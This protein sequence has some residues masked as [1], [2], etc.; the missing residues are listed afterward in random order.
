MICPYL[1]HGVA[2]TAF[3]RTFRHDGK[4]SA[5]WCGG[6]CTPIPFHS[7]YHHIQSCSV[8]SSWVGRYTH[9]ISSLPIYVLCGPYLISRLF[10]HFY[11]FS[12]AEF[13]GMVVL[14]H[15]LWY[16]LFLT[17]IHTV[18]SYIH[19]WFAI[20]QGLP[21]CI[22]PH[23]VLRCFLFRGMARNG[24]PIPW[25]RYTSSFHGT[26]FQVVF[27]NGSGVPKVSFYFCYTDRN[28]EFFLSRRMV[29]NGIPRVCLNFCSKERNSEQF[30]FR[31]RVR[32]GIPKGFCSAEQP[33]FRRN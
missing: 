3:W 29:R 22:L 6:G 10:W 8:R 21:S 17:I 26:E 23:F 25:V 5:G 13:T 9:P 32:N 19:S 18:Q 1:T 31:G 24:I 16:S 33:E 30:L 28:S 27:G 7:I 2:T 14:C 15:S 12:A 20:R 11:T 4:I